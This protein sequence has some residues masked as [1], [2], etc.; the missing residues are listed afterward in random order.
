MNVSQQQDV[1]L[2]CPQCGQQF[3][4]SG[5]LVLDAADQPDVVAALLADSPLNRINLN[6]AM[7]PHCGA[8]VALPLPVLVHDGRV[9]AVVFAPAPG[10]EAYLWGEQARD[11]AA[12]LLGSMP[13]EERRPYLNDVQ[14]AQDTAGVAHLLRKAHR[15]RERR[16]ALA[17]TPAVADPSL[18]REPATP[19]ADDA[20]TPAPSAQVAPLDEGALYAALEAL[21]TVTDAATLPALVAQHPV[22]LTAAADNVLVALADEAATR[23]ERAEAEGW[24]QLR[25]LLARLRVGDTTQPPPPAPAPE[26]DR[27]AAHAPPS[28]APP[29]DAPPSDADALPAAVYE[30][31][32]ATTDSNALV[33][34]VAQYPLLREPW[35]DAAITAEVN[36]TLDAGDE[37]LAAR[38]EERRELLATLPPAGVAPAAA[39]P[40]AADLAAD[41]SYRLLPSVPLATEEAIEAL[42]T[43]DDNDDA[44]AQVIANHPVLLTADVQQAMLQ[45]ASDARQQ[46]D[47]EMATVIVEMRALLRKLR[48]ELAADDEH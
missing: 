25:M 35:A 45:L 2:D 17:A 43:T 8:Q 33:A 12:L 41:T 10:S 1:M 7:C 39:R 9:Q 31:L 20:A 13:L 34:L 40:S 26:P 47:E 21:T 46:G 36:R 11:L 42:L 44:V 24:H 38:L 48:Q 28:D 32:L 19:T 4:A 23:R 3:G 6:S 15:A 22:L 29:S 18:H 27:A 5:W 30:A 14:I 16:A 37:A